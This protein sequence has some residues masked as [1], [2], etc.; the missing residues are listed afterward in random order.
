MDVRSRETYQLVATSLIAVSERLAVV[1]V[2]SDL[3]R[4][5][6]FQS[7]QKAG[8]LQKSTWLRQAPLDR[9]C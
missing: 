2:G 6:P 4:D 8:Q 7:S 1:A 3:R 5:Q 9:S